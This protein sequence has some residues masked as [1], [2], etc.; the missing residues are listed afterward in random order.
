MVTITQADI[1]QA[2]DYIP[3]RHKTAIA[4]LMAQICVRYA[5]NEAHGADMQLP[6]RAVEDRMTRAQC[7]M[8]VLAGFYFKREFPTLELSFETPDGKTVTQ[9][10]ALC[11]DADTLDEWAGSH[12]INQL[13]RLKKDKKTANKVYDLLYDFRAFELMLNGAIREELDKRNDPA[14]R[15]SQMMALQVSPEAMQQ[16]FRALMD[17]KDGGK[18]DG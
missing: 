18:S 5:E 15:M 13:E 8:G 9:P 7:L 10:V 4:G 16:T 1:E 6:D 3:I 12:V 2:R 11:M 17:M 14:L